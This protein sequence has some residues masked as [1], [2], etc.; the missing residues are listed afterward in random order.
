MSGSVAL[1][2]CDS[3]QVQKDLGKQGA[4][5]YQLG[6]KVCTGNKEQCFEQYM[7]DRD[8]CESK[9]VVV[10]YSCEKDQV[11][12]EKKSCPANTQCVKGACVAQP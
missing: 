4:V 3:S 2:V 9:S 1:A 8:F 7:K 6:D 10:K 12:S 5:H 11:K